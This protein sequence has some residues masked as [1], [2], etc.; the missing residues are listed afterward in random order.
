MDDLMS[1][2]LRGRRFTLDAVSRRSPVVAISLATIGLYGV[3][4]Y[5]VSQRRREFGVRMA[6]GA[7]PPEIARMVAARRA[8]AS[9]R[10]AV[11]DRRGW[12]RWRRADSSP[13]LPVRGQRAR[14]DVVRDCVAVGSIA[15][16]LLACVVPARSRND[17]RCG[18]GAARGL[19]TLSRNHGLD[20]TSFFGL[21]VFEW[22]ILD[23]S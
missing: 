3:I 13:S 21:R 15:V 11:V 2:L 12:V 22:V 5:G 7:R 8:D 23:C 10:Q 6:L 14:R 1:A 20:I 4:A 18:G 16:A 19:G 9:R 17:G